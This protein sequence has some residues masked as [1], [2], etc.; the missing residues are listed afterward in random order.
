MKNKI[1]DFLK[2]NKIKFNNKDDMVLYFAGKFTKTPRQI[3]DVLNDMIKRG[4]IY[5]KRKG[6]FV[7]VDELN[8]IKGKIIGTTKGYG[9]L[10]P[11]NSLLPDFFIAE[12][13]LKG[14]MDGDL[15]LAKILSNTQESTEC[16]VV[17]I[18]E[19]ANVNVVGTI[20]YY[21]NKN[22]FVIPDNKKLNIEIFI[23]KKYTMKAQPNFRVVVK[24]NKTKNNKFTGEVIEIL[25]QTDDVK[26]LELGIIRE[27]KLY[28]IF[29]DDVL[30][31]AK[32]I[33]QKVTNEDILNRVDLRNKKIF[34]ID[35]IDAK[36]FDDAV[37]IE[38]KGNN[39]IL[40]VHIADV[41]HY[42]K[43][44]SNLEKEAYTR[45][46][47]AYF[48]NM[49]LPMLPV[50]LSNGIC[51]LLPNEDRLTLSVSMEITPSGEIKNHEIFESV[52]CSCHRLTY[53]QVYKVICGDKNASED[54][55]DI[56]QD[57]LT[58]QELSKIL[59][60]R[61]NDAGQLDLDIGETEIKVDDNYE[62]SFVKKRERNDAH[63][64]IENFM[65]V[66]NETVAKHFALLKLPFVY[67]IHEKPLIQKIK[68]V[69]LFFNGLGI[70]TKE[71]KE[72]TP[73]EIQNL[74]Q[75]TKN[76]PFAEIA[77]KV[78]LRSLQKARY[79]NECYGHFGLALEYYCHFT[80]P[81]RRYPDLV[82][83]RI[84]KDYLHKK[85]NKTKKQELTDFVVDA[86]FRASET[87]KNA[88]LA[89][90][91]VDDLFKAVYIKNHI[92]EEFEG[93]ISGV[94]NYGFYVQLENTVEGLVKVDTLPDGSYL[95]LEKSLK[96]K[97]TSNTFSIGD[98]VKIKVV[99]S[100][101][102]DRKIDFILA[103]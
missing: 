89:E 33:S 51:S 90:R 98:K 86:S 28:E 56:K 29:P 80:S 48:P 39:Y 64:L 92:G 83:H 26:S 27:H 37:S 67:R 21:N 31:E 30:N 87:E 72:I 94:Q 10:A 84:I 91:D 44:N 47:S 12:K 15:V 3:K 32:K 7:C 34:T 95:F 20:T 96:L 46:T 65:V 49:V 61:R 50:E 38:K 82:I 35:G 23:P 74:L 14:A 55:K 101:V 59:E 54:L 85:I 102:F 1:L 6:E 79:L 69:C 41:G 75:L 45:G 17:S 68:D 36:D 11:I 43:Y 66:C 76:K 4:E 60:K 99:N 24:L 22:A 25:G 100:N 70:K 77:N 40:G 103:K 52:I 57:I 8:F 73:I 42:V 9:F 5:E 2:N 78:L 16:E 53:E 62:V 97:G 88:D 93:I 58:M 63:K 81:I 19:N 13:K 71:I 18:L